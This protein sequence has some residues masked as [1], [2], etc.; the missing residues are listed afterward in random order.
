MYI[1]IDFHCKSILSYLDPIG[2]QG[3]YHLMDYTISE[4]L[5]ETRSD[6]E[7]IYHNHGGMT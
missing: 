2:F 3:T 5:C 1:N 6:I 7:E 4:L